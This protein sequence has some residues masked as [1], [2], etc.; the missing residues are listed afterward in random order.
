MKASD[1]ISISVPMADLRLFVQVIYIIEKTSKWG[2]IKIEV[3][4]FVIHPSKEDG[5]AKQREL[6]QVKEEHDRYTTQRARIFKE[7]GAKVKMALV[8]KISS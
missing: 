6:T 1:L 4:E 8:L 3:F 5:I 7:W 2:H